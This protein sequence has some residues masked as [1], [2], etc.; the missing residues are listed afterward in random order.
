MS[1]RFEPN[2]RKVIFRYFRERKSVIFHYLILL[3]IP[4]LVALIG[5]V[6]AWLLLNGIGFVGGPPLAANFSLSLWLFWAR[7]G[8]GFLAV[9]GFGTLL[10]FSLWRGEVALGDL[11]SR[12]WENRETRLVATLEAFAQLAPF[13]WAVYLIS[14]LIFGG[15]AVL[16][17]YIGLWRALVFSLALLLSAPIII[18]THTLR[19]LFFS[20]VPVRDKK[21][22]DEI[23][24]EAS[25]EETNDR[26]IEGDPHWLI[27][28]LA[29]A[30]K[31]RTSRF[32]VGVIIF[33]LVIVSALL[34]P[35]IAGVSYLNSFEARRIT[36]QGNTFRSPGDIHFTFPPNETRPA[37]WIKTEAISRGD[38]L[39][40]V[41]DADLLA[42]AETIPSHLVLRS[43]FYHIE[44]QRNIP[45]TVQIKIRVPR[46]AGSTQ[47]LDLY[48]W[49]GEMWAW[50]PSRRNIDGNL[51]EATLSALP[52]GIALMQS[53]FIPIDVSTTYHSNDPLPEEIR[54]VL[55]TISP[56]G[57]Q[58]S[59]SGDILDNDQAIP[60]EFVITSLNVVP[61]VRNWSATGPV[62]AD[63]I[64][65]L[66]AD[67]RRRDRHIETI[68]DFVQQNG[69]YGID[70]DYRGVAP[71]L[72][73]EYTDFL[74]A[75]RQAL[76]VG[77]QLS[78]HVEFPRQVSADVWETGGYDW[79]AIG[80]LVDVV[81]IPPPSDP[82][83]YAEGQQME[84]LLD[85]AVS[86]MNRYKLQPILR[87]RSVEIGQNVNRDVT[88]AQAMT[89]LGTVERVGQ[90]QSLVLG[91]PIVFTL[92]DLP[93]IETMAV[94]EI[95]GMYSLIYAAEGASRT[96][97]LENAATL[98]NKLQ[99]LARYNLGGVMLLDLLEPDIDPRLGQ[100]IGAFP[101]LVI[102]PLNKSYIISWQVVNEAEQVVDQ[103]TFDLSDPAY[104]WTPDSPGLYEVSAWV[105][106]GQARSGAI[107]LGQTG[108]VIELPRPTP[109][110]LPSAT[111]PPTPTS[112]STSQLSAVSGAP[113]APGTSTPTP[114]PTLIA[115]CATPPQGEFSDLW[116][117]NPEQ[118]GCPV[119]TR[120]LHGTFVQMPFE[121]GQIVWLK[122]IE[123]YGDTGL[124][125][126]VV[127]GQNEGAT[128]T[129]SLE[130]E[131]WAGEGIC[132]VGPPPE[133]LFLPDRNLAQVWCDM[134][135]LDILGYATILNEIE[136]TGGEVA[137]QNFDHV[138]FLKD[139][140]G[141]ADGLVYILFRADSSYR[142]VAY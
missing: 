39:E 19:Y 127:G 139:W 99:F 98:S 61:T 27:Y 100:V 23:A 67:Q 54:E 138:I 32:I 58:L 9:I 70:L 22:G 94:D 73:Q 59:G 133:G 31:T 66:L 8:F 87:T 123:R 118:F 57:F 37:F 18:V 44:R 115:G 84:A 71:N 50:R 126:A 60:S 130:T 125:I 30:L 46:D 3:T 85:W 33:P 132:P 103:A 38:F 17:L 10:F 120:P 82:T 141:H 78:V 142:R 134:N 69:Y 89:H 77:K 106:V 51:V 13:Y 76:P 43:P 92:S 109:T 72:R 117:T 121:R 140:Q 2:P 11:S 42:A 111:P 122:G 1:E 29:V 49:D 102:P 40:G 24:S 83:V 136:A 7:V 34:I 74:A 96:I 110:P 112:I 97:H 80:R 128:G 131:N 88:L 6:L 45:E 52:E 114:T 20:P 116:L 86:R 79:Q 108:V 16:L 101:D 55:T 4:A 105:Q 14:T 135:G 12:F 47:A 41:N 68:V 53:G 137:L 129:W 75:L 93:T 36:E 90:G 28:V 65:N 104:V 21:A 62:Q 5:G 56:Q 64:N 26:M 35:L 81:K 63:L 25:S 113:N 107:T 119:E 15:I 95:S 124:A 91:D 48:I